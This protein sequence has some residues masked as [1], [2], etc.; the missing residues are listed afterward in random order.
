MT[1]LTRWQPFREM[2]SMHNMLDRLMDQSFYTPVFE[3]NG[4]TTLIP[5]DVYQTDEEVHVKATVPGLK[6]EDIQISVTGDTLSISGETESEHEEK[7][8]DYFV[9]ERRMGSFSRSITLPVGVDADK[10]KADFEDGV[11]TITLPKSEAEKPKM[12]SVKSVKA[13]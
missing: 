1:E 9:R 3:T 6:P 11:L 8:R 2:R 12:I 4:H 13:K 5:I 10:A 7:D